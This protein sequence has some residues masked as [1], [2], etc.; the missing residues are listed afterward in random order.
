MEAP[1]YYSYSPDT[2]EYAG[3]AFARESPLEP[4]VYMFPALTTQI[5]P[6][7][8]GALQVA[9][10]DEEA[11]AWSLVPDHRGSTWFSIATGHAM[12]VN[13]IGDPR[14]H[15]LTD[16][17]PPAL[18]ARQARAWVNDGWAVIPDRR[19][20]TW[21][22][23]NGVPVLVEHVG[24]PADLALTETPP[25]L[26]TDEERVSDR[27]VAAR[28]TLRLLLQHASRSILAPY[29]EAEVLGW[30][31]KEI[32]ARHILAASPFEM[33]LAP[34]LEAECRAASPDTLGPS[35]LEAA[36][37]AKAQSVVAR[38]GEFRAATG[39]IAGLRQR[40]EANLEAAQSVNQIEAVL[41]T[42]K[43]FLGLN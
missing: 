19:G 5:A 3:S 30:T 42:T 14:D 29:P 6:P 15:G 16:L 11:G 38:A 4:G 20:E 36:V 31:A 35:A 23:P 22:N 9:C 12:R 25:D 8:G 17:Q 43:T 33:A 34:V 18:G 27:R 1:R 39:R 28:D 26:R 13:E 7:P 32:E 10:F 41:E 24:D 40:M 37:V 21:Y 2:G